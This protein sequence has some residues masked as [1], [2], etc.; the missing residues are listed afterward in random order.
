[1]YRLAVFGGL[2]NSTALP[3]EGISPGLGDTLARLHD[4]Y[5]ANV[6][7]HV[8]VGGWMDGWMDGWGVLC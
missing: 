3:N 4:I 5:V 2:V 8:F 6:L 7:L 1:M